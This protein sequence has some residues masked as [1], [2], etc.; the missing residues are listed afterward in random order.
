MAAMFRTIARVP[1]RLR[2]ESRNASWRLAKRSTAKTNAEAHASIDH[3]NHDW[4]RLIHSHRSGSPRSD[5]T[6]C[7]TMEV[8][9]ARTAYMYRTV[10]YEPFLGLYLYYLLWAL[11]D[12]RGLIATQVAFHAPV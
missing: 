5:V 11:G 10:L 3:S 8:R 7:V 12:K 1:G 4:F 2:A 6:V 9:I